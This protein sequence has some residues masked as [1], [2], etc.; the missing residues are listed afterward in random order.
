[1]LL[2][3]RDETTGDGMSDRQ[4]RDEVVTI[5]A[6]GHETTAVAMSWTWY[7]L[8][9]HPRCEARLHQE[10][11]QV[12]AGRS[13]RFADL[14]HLPYTRMV[15]EEALRLYPPAFSLTR[16]AAADDRIGPHR[17]PKGAMVTLSPWVTHRDPRLWPD[18]E[19]FD[20]ERFLPEAVR[21]RHKFAYFPFGGGPR[22]CIGNSFALMEGRL[23]LATL[24]QRYRLRLEPGHPVEPQGRITLRPRHGM[25]MTIEER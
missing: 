11:D 18:P 9:R 14:E 17:I 25:R 23:I 4:L 19:R 12:L 6:A 24:A 2:A 13:P 1:M 3:A 7:L 20:P 22:V 5:F 16:V 15:F 8:S 21:Q 10:L